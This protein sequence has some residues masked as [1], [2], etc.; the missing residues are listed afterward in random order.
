MKD[1]WDRKGLS[2]AGYAAAGEVMASNGADERESQLVLLLRKW[3]A[4]AGDRAELAVSYLLD[5]MTRTVGYRNTARLQ[6]VDRLAEHYDRGIRALEVAAELLMTAHA[7]G[8]RMASELQWTREQFNKARAHLADLRSVLSVHGCAMPVDD[9]SRW[10]GTQLTSYR[11]LLGVM[12]NNGMPDGHEGQAAEAW[13]SEVFDRMSQLIAALDD[14]NGAV[15][16]ES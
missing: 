5:A 15:A 2:A 7:H 13:L 16:N 10:I 1:V 12:R 3:D 8:V 4:V 9:G 6:R 11:N 14:L